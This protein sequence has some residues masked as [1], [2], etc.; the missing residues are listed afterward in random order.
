M[1]ENMKMAM[2]AVFD[3]VSKHLCV[4]SINVEKNACKIYVKFSLSVKWRS[5]DCLQMALQDIMEELGMS[6]Y[7]RLKYVCVYVDTYRVTV[8]LDLSKLYV[9]EDSC[10]FGSRAVDT[11]ED[12]IYKHIRSAADTW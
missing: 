1:D 7:E 2:V 9:I 11:L 5:K 8:V 6:F 3:G 10:D 4:R 12:V